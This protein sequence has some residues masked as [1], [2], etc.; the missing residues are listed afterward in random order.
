MNWIIIITL[1]VIGI[2]ALIIE[3]LVV[4]GAVVGILGSISIVGGIVFSY[5]EYGIKAGNITLFTTAAAIIITAILILRSKTWKRIALDTKIDSK[6]NT[7]S[8]RLSVGMEGICISRLAPGGKGKFGDE[9][10]EVFSSHDFI[11]VNSPI[12]ITQIDGNKIIVKLK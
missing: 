6:M 10:V 7:E 9:I 8:E 11:D 4:P 5:T 3:F 1:I 12:I 2:I